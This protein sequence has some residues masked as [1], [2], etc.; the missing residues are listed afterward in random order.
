MRLTRRA[1]RHRRRP[2]V[3]CKALF[4]Y[5]AENEDELSF[6]PG[7]VILNVNALERGGRWE[8]TLNGKKGWFPGVSD[9]IDAVAAAL[10]RCAVL[11]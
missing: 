8:G 5:K 6:Q 3:S 10:A 9:S 2:G 11:C 1:S 4:D 7:D